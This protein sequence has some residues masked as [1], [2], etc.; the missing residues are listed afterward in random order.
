MINEKISKA[1]SDEII[2]YIDNRRDVKEEGFLKDKPKKNKQ[3]IISNGAIIARLLAVI[4]KVTNH[5][6]EVSSIEKAKKN[7]TQ[8]NLEFQRSRYEQL[9][10]LVDATS[11]D[12]NLVDIKNEYHQFLETN[13]EFFNT[14]TWLTNYSVKAK[15]I[16]FATHVGKLT[17]SSSKSSSILDVSDEKKE[18]YL[19]TNTLHNIEIDTASSNA[20]SLPIADILKITVDGISVLDCLKKNDKSLFENLTD[21]EVLINEWCEQLKQAYDS[22]EKQSYFLSKQTYFPVESKQYHLLLPLTSSS[23]VHALH[24]EH[25]KYWDEEQEKVR[26]QRY[27]KKY[28]PKM[29]CS[30]PNKAYIHVTGSNHSNASS[31]NGKRGGR[32]SLLPAMPPQWQSTIPSYI[33][34]TD[35]FD[36]TLS[37]VLKVEMNDLKKYLLLIKNKSLSIS[38]PKRNATVINKLR[39]ISGNFFNYI[40]QINLHTSMKNWTVETRLPIE[41]QLLFE[42]FRDDDKAITVKQNKQ[43]MEVLSK[44]YG[45]WLNNQLKDKDKLPLTL[46]HE[47]VWAD[48]FLIELREFVATQEVTL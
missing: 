13:R 27:S 30:Y 40:E 23:L 26:S 20:A 21:N 29:S 8:T 45:R 4:K 31:L 36:R 32:I 37:F 1:L 38:E 3:G 44:S 42:Y 28:M 5:V 14:V 6:D 24:L 16:S 9:L 17:H 25:K 12:N 35:V 7:K 15:D 18:D 34:K 43:W 48:A 10:S 46:I 22:S 33:N 47:A 2:K 11:V 19:T 41:Q 39:A